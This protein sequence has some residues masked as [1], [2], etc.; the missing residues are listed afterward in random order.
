MQV[1]FKDNKNSNTKF[2]DYINIAEKL[3][4]N[5][6]FEKKHKPRH[7][8]KHNIPYCQVFKI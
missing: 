1:P 6:D 5:D 7:L 4:L 3:R 8:L 2:H